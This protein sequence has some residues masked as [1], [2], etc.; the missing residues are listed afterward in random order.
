MLSRQQVALER[1]IAALHR[2]IW[3]AE[4]D[5][6]ALGAFGLAEDLDALSQEVTRIGVALIERS[7]SR[8]R[9]LRLASPAA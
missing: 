7:G 2:A 4:S 6:Q 5:A 1:S 3:R 9:Q 8:T